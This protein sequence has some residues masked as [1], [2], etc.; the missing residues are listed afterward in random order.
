MSDDFDNELIFADQSKLVADRSNGLALPEGDADRGRFLMD[1]AT[2]AKAVNALAHIIDDPMTEYG[3]LVKAVNALATLEKVNAEKDRAIYDQQRAKHREEFKEKVHND[4]L[5]SQQREFDYKVKL[6]AEKMAVRKEMHAAK[7]ALER[8]KHELNLEYKSVSIQQK[9]QYYERRLEHTAKAKVLEVEAKLKVV[10][11]QSEIRKKELERKLEHNREMQ[12]LKFEASKKL[13]QAKIDIED[14][15]A[16]AEAQEIPPMKIVFTNSME[17]K[18]GS[19]KIVGE[20]MLPTEPSSSDPTK[21]ALPAPN[22]DPDDIAESTSEGFPEEM[23]KDKYD[24]R[25]YAL[26][27]DQLNDPQIHAV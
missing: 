11:S 21:A 23:L 14:G 24:C 19:P 17:D 27:G 20:I 16:E 10:D 3:D 4:R 2:R 13:L 26:E 1:P 7:L 22:Q 15:R 6:E 25:S 18:I 9:Q 8:E 5:E 12:R